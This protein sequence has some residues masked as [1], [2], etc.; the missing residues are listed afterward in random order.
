[1][2]FAWPV[3]ELPA[4]MEAGTALTFVAGPNEDG[5]T[6]FRVDEGPHKYEFFIAKCAPIKVITGAVT[7]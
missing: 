1:M 7:F 4:D 5:D 6:L 3:N 2:S